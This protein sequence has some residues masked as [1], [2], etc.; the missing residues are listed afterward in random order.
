MSTDI[1]SC[2]RV[3]TILLFSQ[4]SRFEQ[5]N[6]WL[7]YLTAASSSDCALNEAKSITVYCI[8]INANNL[9]ISSS[10]TSLCCVTNFTAI[11]RRWTVAN[12]L[13]GRSRCWAHFL[14]HNASVHV[15]VNRYPGVIRLLWITSLK[16]TSCLLGENAMLL[17]LQE[18]TT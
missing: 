9:R 3:I 7:I 12:E 5:E 10:Y 15:A 18:S 13:P 11:L 6:N 8:D 16:M 14:T 2:L 4:I 1:K 17:A